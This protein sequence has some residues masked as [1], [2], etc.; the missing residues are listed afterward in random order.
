MVKREQLGDGFQFDDDNAFDEHI[1]P[2]GDVSA[3]SGVI[4]GNGDLGLYVQPAGTEFM[5]QAGPVDVFQ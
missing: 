1:D 3:N 4:E 5:T 2:E